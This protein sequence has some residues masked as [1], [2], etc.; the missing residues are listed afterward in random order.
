MLAMFQAVQPVAVHDSYKESEEE[1]ADADAYLPDD[2][3]TYFQE[4]RQ[5]KE[6]ESQGIVQ[7]FYIFIAREKE[8]NY[9]AT[10]F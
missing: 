7:P 10:V 1:S 6:Q 8:F 9:L 3:M 2:G 5:S 4:N